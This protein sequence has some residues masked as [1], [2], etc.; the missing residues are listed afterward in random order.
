M[1]GLFFAEVLVKIYKMPN[2]TDNTPDSLNIN[3]GNTVGYETNSSNKIKDPDEWT[4]GT[5]PMTGAQKSYLETLQDGTVDENITKATASKQIE[6]AIEKNAS[7]ANAS[8]NNTIKDPKDWVTGSEE[9]TGAQRSYL[10]TLADEAGES[11]DENLTKA[12]AS[13]KIEALQH[14]T[15]RGLNNPDSD[16]TS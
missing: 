1:G 10:K 15:G 14:K 16:K 3:K 11:V 2:K 4:T 13:E 7:E 5:E 9:M 6:D 8:G 12:Q